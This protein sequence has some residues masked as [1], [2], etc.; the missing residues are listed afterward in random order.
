MAFRKGLVLSFGLV[1][2]IVALNGATESEDTLTT[3]C[4]GPSASSHVPT[5]I[6]QER[7]CT[8][9]GVVSYADLK[10]ARKTGTDQYQV[11]EQTEVKAVAEQAA[12]VTK[13]MLTLTVHDSDEVFA[14]TMQGESVYYVEPDG[15]AQV[16]GYSLLLDAVQRHPEFAFLTTFTPTSKQGMYQLKAFGDSLVLASLRWPEAV[17]PVP[18]TGAVTPDDGLKVQM[19]MLLTSMVQPFEPAAYKDDYKLALNALIAS[20]QAVAGVAPDKPAKADKTVAATGLVDLSASLAAMLGNVAPATPAKK[21][22]AR[23]AS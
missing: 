3:V 11:I 6:T 21:T 8:T 12:G 17:R 4:C 19:D 14:S 15:V 18:N 5:P 1:N 16:G 23:K 13:K 7:K 10:K 2:V 9:C 22:R 20:K